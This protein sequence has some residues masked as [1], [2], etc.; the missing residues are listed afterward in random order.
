LERCTRT[1]WGFDTAGDLWYILR[2]SPRG[3]EPFDRL[4]GVWYHLPPQEPRDS[5]LKNASGS[6]C[7]LTTG[8]GV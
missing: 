7:L 5:R 1:R 8:R 6:P 2:R 4:Q 3:V